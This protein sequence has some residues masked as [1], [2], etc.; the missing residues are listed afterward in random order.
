MLHLIRETYAGQ[1][2][3]FD[4]GQCLLTRSNRAKK[5][6]DWQTPRVPSQRLSSNQS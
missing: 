6:L 5:P 1:Q 2:G 3:A 4:L